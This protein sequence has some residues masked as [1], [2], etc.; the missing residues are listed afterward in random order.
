MKANR[1]KLELAMARACMDM[2]DLVKKSAMPRPTVNNVI[3]GRDVRPATI[4][5]IARALDVDVADI[6]EVEE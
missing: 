5:K 6:L 2:V 3:M 1:K 4:G